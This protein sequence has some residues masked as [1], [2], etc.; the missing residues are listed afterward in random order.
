M[1]IV[2][3]SLLLTTYKINEIK[4]RAFIVYFGNEKVG[5]VREQEEAL[6]ILNDIKK[7]L[8]NTYDI[9]IVLNDDI[10]FEGTHS[11][12][13]LLV[14]PDEI[15]RNIRSKITFL[16]SGYVLLV[17]NKEIGAT[18]TKKDMEKVIEKIKE[19][20]LDKRDENSHLKEVKFIEDVKIEKRNI[21]LNKII[22]KD[23]LLRYVQTGEK[24]IKTHTVK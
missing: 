17:D 18:K 21:P 6:D 9:D 14:T 24:E 19:P 1:F 13:D 2:I 10:S 16:V 11:K 23:E 8:T 22:D 12:D 5:V 7:E 15:K 20:Y 3:A 4:T